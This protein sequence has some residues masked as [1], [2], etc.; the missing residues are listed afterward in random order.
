[1]NNNK[2]LY[3][4]EISGITYGVDDLPYTLVDYNI[5]N[6]IWVLES[7]DDLLSGMDNAVQKINISK[8]GALAGGY[9]F[10]FSVINEDFVK[11]IDLDGAFF[12][13]RACTL[14]I[15]IGDGDVS[16]WTGII[17]S[18]TRT[19][20][21][22]VVFKCVDFIKS[23]DIN[24]GSEKI[25]IA[26]NRNYNCKLA[27]QNIVKNR[28]PLTKYPDIQGW[29]IY[30][31]PILVGSYR[32]DTDDS[33]IYVKSLFTTPYD[34]E[35]GFVKIIAGLGSGDIYKLK[36]TGY[37]AV[38]MYIILEGDI[39]GKL[40]GT[41]NSSTNAS[42]IE[43]YNYTYRYTLSNKRV[44]FVH[45]NNNTNIKKPLYVKSDVNIDIPMTLPT[46]YDEN[47][48]TPS[49][50]IDI[51]GLNDNGIVNN[52][53]DVQCTPI[54]QNFTAKTSSLNTKFEFYFEYSS[55]DV[56]KI[57]NIQAN[58]TTY[59]D[60]GIIYFTDLG[61]SNPS[62]EGM[63]TEILAEYI[64]QEDFKT[65]LSTHYITTP[66]SATTTNSPILTTVIGKDVK[67]DFTNMVNVGL[68]LFD[69]NSIDFDDTYHI[70]KLY[71][72][73]TFYIDDYDPNWNLN[74][75]THTETKVH[76]KNDIKVQ[77]ISIGCN[78]E[79]VQSGNEFES[80]TDT[81]KYIQTDYG[82]ISTSNIDTASY[83]Q[84]ENLFDK[85]PSPTTRNACKQ[86]TDQKSINLVYKEILYS[87][88]LG[89]FISRDGKYTMENWLPYST[90]FYN[91]LY[92]VASFNDTNCIDIGDIKRDSLTT[93]VSD[94]ELKYD[95]NESTD[96]FQKTMRIKNTNESSFD[97]DR[98]TEGVTSDNYA[99]AE[100]AWLLLRAGYLRTKNS[101]QTKVENEWIKSFYSDGTGEGEALAFIRN[102]AGH[103]NRQHEYITIT[104]P[105][106]RSNLDLE[107]LSFINIRDSKI[108]GG[109]ER[110]G[111]I[112]DR[113]LDVKKDQI[114]LKLLLDI[115]ATDPY[116]VEIGVVQ[117]DANEIGNEWIDD[118]TSVDEISDGNGK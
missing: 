18:Y 114:Q 90:V 75:L 87:H 117:D 106:I 40:L 33:Y 77:D 5:N 70:S 100:E 34:I 115:S 3:R 84:S 78:G 44:N 36:Y 111:W 85:L 72:K 107:L 1:M 101:S 103:V 51:F 58:G 9:T 29:D 80:V 89:M 102:Q 88:H 54:N 99:E 109:V 16:E 74:K 60:A 105:Y 63:T 76:I 50:K 110:A 15:D 52:I 25:P 2:I 79:N 55:E 95:K 32:G 26:L 92:P 13:N 49:T 68:E 48:F 4:I 67:V 86:I 7:D 57:K 28:L 64:N 113:K 116:L 56:N 94:F 17:D 96:K 53:S 39:T 24:I 22:K 112:V 6:G 14:Y 108:T 73:L 66:E 98:D 10:G 97:F 71:N 69:M 8:G 20:E 83:T 65:L 62:I 19:T 38:G 93:V 47:F 59:L 91:D 31:T 41:D 45:D 37:D 21:T 12:N 30:Y 43:V 104:I 61:I 42:L 118:S 35:D 46:A 23:R 81:I 11:Q 27:D 82:N